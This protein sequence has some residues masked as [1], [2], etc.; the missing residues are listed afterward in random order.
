[1][2]VLVLLSGIMLMVP[3]DVDAPYQSISQILLVNPYASWI[4]NIHYWSAQL[5][6]VLLLLH[7]YEHFKV[8]KPIR[9]KHVVWFRLTLSLV[10]L[11]L[12]M[13]TGFLLRGD[14]DTLQ[15]RQIVER[16]TREI[17][18][19]GNLLAYIIFGKPG[20]Y[21]LI[22]LNHAATFTIII[23]VFVFEHSRKLWPEIKTFVY[24]TL[25]ILVTSFWFNAPLHDNV[26]PT[27]K[28]P[29]Y[30]LGLQDLLF[31]F[32]HPQWLLVIL[33]AVLMLVYMAGYKSKQV[34]FWSRRLL[35]VLTMGYV[36]LSLDGLFFRGENWH[37]IFPWQQ[38]Y[39]YQV[40]DAYHLGRSDFSSGKYADKVND[41]PMING[42]QESCL[43]CHHNTDGFSTS[44]D[45]KI[46]GCY[47]C[48]GG[49]PFS[50]N[51]REAH[52]GMMLIPGNLS[53]AGR[54]CGT[55][56]CHPDIVNRID[57]GLMATLSGMINVDRYV[58]NEQSTP[59]GDA[60]L[61]ALHHTA[62]DEHLKNLCV[63][64]HLG[65]E[66]M[67]TGP[68]TEESR[69]GGCLA[70]HL[71]YDEKALQTHADRLAQSVIPTAVEG[72]RKNH[73]FHHPSIDL[74]VTNNHCFGCHSRSGRISTN[75]EGWHETTFKPADVAG[76]SGYRLVEGSRVFR[77]VQD[78]VHHAAGMD[79]ID[80]HTSYELMGDGKQYQHQEQQQDV[81]CTDCHTRH[82]DTIN[83]L[84]MDGESAIIAGMR[85]GSMAGKKVLRTKKHK[86]PL[87]NTFVS[88]DSIYLIGKNNRKLHYVKPP[89]SQCLR[90]KAH[91]N[92]SCSA[93]HSAWAPTCIGCHNEYDPNEPGYNMVLNK[94]QRGSWVEYVGEYHAL[95]PSLGNRIDTAG[96]EIIP[97][98]PG[99]ILT[100]APQSFDKNAHDSLIFQRLYAPAAPHTIMKKG[101][102]CKSCHNSPLALGYGDGRLNY[103]IKNGKGE[104]QFQPRYANSE[105]DGLPEDA[106]IPMLG[107]RT[108]K[109]ATR[110]NVTPLSIEQQQKILTVG[111]CLTCHDEQSAVL[112]QSLQ[113]FSAAIKNRKKAC[114]L[115]RW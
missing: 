102:S 107:S 3:F 2:F 6:L 14:A 15:A 95:P 110:S 93:C 66:K 80:C 67:A 1:M 103:V 71:N 85:F 86:V 74:Q 43:L 7:L 89:G 112:Q 32:S 37:R 91:Q 87:I 48:H 78:D 75:Y 9:L 63:R 82:P 88:D 70:C 90:D 96:H 40:F 52:K 26:N 104:W 73:I 11:F 56:N 99:M 12:V 10:I 17:P 33:T 31:R 109:V 59:D 77:K 98:V 20:S 50:M 39:S 92:V 106:W 68:V 54:S 19:V 5:F 8:K 58:F 79:C 28:G 45:P 53:V 16:L 62:A 22:Y 27:V 83:P 35:L 47:S 36:L 61:A 13:F 30:F 25:I 38:G 55:T 57:N 114:V 60:G 81:A 76:K 72:S 108:G 115:P 41:S 46:M 21:Q 4:R 49:N 42:R 51:E 94:E 84:Q 29:W 34:W 113:D 23:L 111:S 65:N 44:H 18:W 64:C 97:V 101:R 105:H 24:A 69:G 100:I